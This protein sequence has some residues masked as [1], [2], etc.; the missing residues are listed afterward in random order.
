MKAASR[1]VALAVVILFATP[2]MSSAQ[3]R[4]LGRLTGTVN[5][6]TGTPLK[7]VFV[8]ATMTGEEGVIEEKTDDKGV[9]AVNG[10]AKGEWHFT[11]QTPGYTPVGAKVV[12]QAELARINPIAIVLK[13][14]AK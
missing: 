7:D 8:R 5:D 11:F 13:K 2:M 3:F 1:Y 6:E 4:G 9:W 10:L 14:S 12:L